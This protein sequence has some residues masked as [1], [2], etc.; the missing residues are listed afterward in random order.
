MLIAVL[1]GD[2][3]L[4]LQAFAAPKTSGLWDEVRQ[5]FASAVTP[6]GRRAARRRRARSA[7]SCTRGCTG[8]TRRRPARQLQP[9]RFLGVDGPRWFLR[10]VITRPGRPPPGAA[11]PLEEVFAERRRGPRRPSG[12]APGPAGDP[13]ARGGAGRPLEEQMAGRRNRSGDLPNPFER[14][15]E[16]TETR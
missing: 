4:Q 7:S 16:I 1:R 3:A 15:P 10:G 14:G 11:A 2:S 12:A 13:A 6:G 8:W 5:E 9:V